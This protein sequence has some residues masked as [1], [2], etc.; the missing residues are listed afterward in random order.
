MIVIA[1]YFG[2]VRR[3]APLP[4]IETERIIRTAPDTDPACIKSLALS[5][6]WPD[7]MNEDGTHSE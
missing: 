1:N 4:V 5:F 7:Y 6:V 3:D 2:V